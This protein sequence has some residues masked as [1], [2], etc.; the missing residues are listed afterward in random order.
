[1]TTCFNASWDAQIRANILD[2]IENGILNLR[3]DA[4]CATTFN[5]ISNVNAPIH[6][7]KLASAWP[8]PLGAVRAA[9]DICKRLGIQKLV[10]SSLDLRSLHALIEDGSWMTVPWRTVQVEV[11]GGVGITDDS[12]AT[13]RQIARLASEIQSVKTIIH[14]ST[15]VDLDVGDLSG[16]WVKTGNHPNIVF[17]RIEGVRSFVRSIPKIQAW[18]KR[19]L[20]RYYRPDGQGAK[21]AQ[22]DFEK[23]IT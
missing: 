3:L 21:N 20:E 7:A 8:E 22:S 5:E 18:K 15:Y 11:T 1:M 13:T 23:R 6:T 12:Q 14:I 16:R 4:A 17:T 2:A 10:L 19:T 9:I